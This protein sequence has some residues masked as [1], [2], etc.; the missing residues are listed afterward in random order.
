M[1]AI[2][3]IKEYITAPGDEFT[4]ASLQMK[5]SIA[6]WGYCNRNGNCYV[7]LSAT[8]IMYMEMIDETIDNYILKDD[9]DKDISGTE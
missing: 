3:T 6:N 5:V 7:C 1:S 8:P 2:T 9:I 4:S